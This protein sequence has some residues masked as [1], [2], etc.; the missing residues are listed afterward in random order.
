MAFKKIN[1]YVI[2]LKEILGKGSY[3]EV[4]RG[5][6]EG[7]RKIFA[8][9]VLTKMLSTPAA[10][11]STPTSTCGAPSCRRSRSCSR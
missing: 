6:Q 2:H 10:I 1:G 9:K 7:T 8:I 3:G 11:Q 5:E 4:Y